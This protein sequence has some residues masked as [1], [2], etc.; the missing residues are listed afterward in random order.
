MDGQVVRWRLKPGGHVLMSVSRKRVC[1]DAYADNTTGVAALMDLLSKA[2]RV[3]SAL[4]AG[5]DQSHL[6]EEAE[7]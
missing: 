1:I 6:I 5:V 4:A 2:D 7:K 3:R